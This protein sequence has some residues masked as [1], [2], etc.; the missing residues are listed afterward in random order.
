[1]GLMSIH[2]QRTNWN[3]KKKSAKCCGTKKITRWNIYKQLSRLPRRTCL[4]GTAERTYIFGFLG[5]L[6]LFLAITPRHVGSLVYKMQAALL[7]LR[8]TLKVTYQYHRSQRGMQHQTA[9][10]NFVPRAVH[11]GLGC[12]RCTWNPKNTEKKTKTTY[13]LQCT[14]YKTTF[15]NSNKTIYNCICL[16]FLK[17]VFKFSVYQAQILKRE[18]IM[19][20]VAFH[21]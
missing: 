4:K 3:L 5:W 6:H 12:L 15:P 20:V 17:K 21:K 9:M 10:W 11:M 2:R 1:M 8:G 16:Q 14:P 7:C 18:T 19:K 13:H